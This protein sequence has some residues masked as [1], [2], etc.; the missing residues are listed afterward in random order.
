[1]GVGARFAAAACIQV[2]NFSE[3][4]SNDSED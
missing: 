2:D 4:A 3:S 1:M